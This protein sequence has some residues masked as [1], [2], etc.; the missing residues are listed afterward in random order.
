MQDLLAR[1]GITGGLTHD[2]EALSHDGLYVPLAQH[3]KALSDVQNKQLILQARHPL[4]LYRAARILC[5]LS[6]GTDQKVILL[7]CFMAS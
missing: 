3:L 2:S 4:A 6:A 7:C 5:H 1:A